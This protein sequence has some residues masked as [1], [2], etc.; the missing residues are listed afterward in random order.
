MAVLTPDE[1]ILGMIAV[2]GRHGYQLID[3]FQNPNILGEIWKMSTSQIYAVLKR[4]EAQDM[5]TGQVLESDTAPSRTEYG[6]TAKGQDRL[7][8]WLDEAEPSASIRRV[9]VEFLSRLYIAG[10]LNLPAG[11]IV[12]RQKAACEAERARLLSQPKRENIGALAHDLMIAQLDTVL[13]WIESCESLLME[14]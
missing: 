13:R 3:Q 14:P 8:R 5:I 1:T 7:E 6:L 12:K 2:H 11:R 10:A 4:L 9:R